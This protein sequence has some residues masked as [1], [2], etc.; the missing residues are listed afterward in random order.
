MFPSKFL[1]VMINIMDKQNLKTMNLQGA[2]PIRRRQG[3]YR[4]VPLRQADAWIDHGVQ[5]VHDQVGHDQ[6]EAVE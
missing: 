3:I 4:L 1:P 2:R 6:N 5:D